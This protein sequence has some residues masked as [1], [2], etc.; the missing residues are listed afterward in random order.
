MKKLISKIAIVAVACL[1]GCATGPNG[2][3]IRSEVAVWAEDIA[4]LTLIARPEYRPAIEAAVR[5]LDGAEQ[6]EGINLNTITSALLQTDALQSTDSK[7][8]VIGGR[9][10]FRRA[11]GNATLETP[12]SLNLAGLGLRDGLKSALNSVQ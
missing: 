12:E 6:A 8:A 11:L 3:N 7:L 9:L 5:A 10:I 1:L 2:T 4:V